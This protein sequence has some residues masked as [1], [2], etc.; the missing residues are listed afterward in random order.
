[1]RN[2]VAAL[3]VVGVVAVLAGWAAVRLLL[4]SGVARTTAPVVT[5]MAED[6]HRQAAPLQAMTLASTQRQSSTQPKAVSRDRALRSAVV[7]A[8]LA[9]LPA[10]LPGSVEADDQEERSLARDALEAVVEFLEARSA[11]DAAAY[12]RWATQRGLQLTSSLTHVFPN[13][14]AK[15]LLRLLRQTYQSVGMTPPE[16]E[17]TPRRLFVDMFGRDSEVA[18][19][20]PMAVVV[21]APAVE[22]GWLRVRDEQ[23]LDPLPRMLRSDSL[24]GEFWY[25][26]VAWSGVR[27]WS[28]PGG[29]QA[30]V[31]K[32]RRGALAALVRLVVVGADGTR[33]PMQFTV[34]RDEARNAWQVLRVSLHNVL[35]T[36]EG[37]TVEDPGMY[38]F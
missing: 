23:D 38:I 7:D 16:G 1:M 29:L 22:L 10:E 9:A 31:Q 36:D 20:K 35:F 6:A 5:A 24:G 28:A 32:D 37:G 27:L 34:V 15:R 21:E 8:L 33:T 11:G 12:E 30:M 13:V 14:D 25:G 3:A 17:I 4:H 26:G 18:A 19:L 2:K